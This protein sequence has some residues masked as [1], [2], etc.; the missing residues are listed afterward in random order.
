MKWYYWNM[1]GA[2]MSIAWGLH[3][4]FERSAE[5]G[6][7]SLQIFAKSPRGRSIPSY[8][9]EQ[10]ALAREYRTRYQQQWG[11]IHANYLANLSKPKQEC[12]KDIASILHDFVVAHHTWFAAVNVHIG[13]QK[14][15]TTKDEAFTNMAKNLEYILTENRKKSYTPL[16]LFEITAG[17]GS[18]LGTS[19]EEIGYF[20]T[21]YLKDYPVAFCFDTAH[22]RAAWNDLTHRDEVI[23]RWQEHIGQEKLFAFH[24]NDAKV[25]LWSRLDRHAPLGRGMI[26]RMRIIPLIQR[27]EKHNKPLYL[28]TTDPERRPAEIARV[29][30]IAQGKTAAVEALHKKEFCSDILK[31]FHDTGEQSWLR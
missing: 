20:F 19:I 29:R 30:D 21:N 18:E 16:F 15:F 24:L 22:A 17:Q 10:Y 2:H 7:N 8:T 6:W 4:A 28:E 27:A 1:I 13:K 26:G 12:E 9:D 11:I 25:P 14:W 3:L 5:I 31:K 23:G